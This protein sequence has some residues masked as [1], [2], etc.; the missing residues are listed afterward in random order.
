MAGVTGDERGQ[1]LL[2][3]AIGLGVLFVTLALIL[4]TAIYTG[5]LAA[6]DTTTE[7][8]RE[9]Q[10]VQHNVVQN[11]ARTLRHVN[12]ANDTTHEALY[13]NL[14]SGVTDWSRLLD[15]H[16]VATGA[17]V[18]VSVVSVQNGTEIVQDNSSR[19]FT[20]ANAAA[21]W[22]LAESVTEVRDVRMNVTREGLTEIED[23]SCTPSGECY[24][25][26]IE[27]GSD[28][29]RLFAYT[30]EGESDISVEVVNASG[31]SMTCTTTGESAWIN[32]TAGTFAGSG[33]P[34]LASV[35]D[36]VMPDP[37][38]VTYANGDQITGSYR[39]TVDREISLSPHFSTDR[40][41]SLR[42]T[43]YSANV[44]FGYRS[45]ELIYRTEFRVTPGDGNA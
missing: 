43:I 1:L 22:T 11:T 9:I 40:S 30:S 33:C 41:P 34:A 18:N 24:Y 23:D 14:S 16:H 36:D 38:N 26:E 19:N 8:G 20:D 45:T 32:V 2:I 31:G 5:S 35:E 44:S 25:L 13:A 28:T 39:L 7:E 12:E 29:W 4:N 15:R 27:N 17:A 3:S 42:P 6:K 21:N 37:F 10:S